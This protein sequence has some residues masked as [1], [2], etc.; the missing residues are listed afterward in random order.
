MLKAASRLNPRGKKWMSKR[1][2]SMWVS[3]GNR[4]SVIILARL[5]NRPTDQVVRQAQKIQNL[6]QK[7][8]KRLNKKIKIT[9]SFVSLCQQ[10]KNHREGTKRQNLIVRTKTSA[11]FKIKSSLYSTFAPRCR[12]WETKNV[13]IHLLRSFKNSMKL[14]SSRLFWSRST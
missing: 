13:R 14:L 7:H 5:R 4:N 3:Q 11:V 9:H 6:Y 1:Q 2:K 12:A 8:P 10:N